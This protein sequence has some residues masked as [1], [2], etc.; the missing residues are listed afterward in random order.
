MDNVNVQKEV[1]NEENIE[2]K[3]YFIFTI[4]VW[5]IAWTIS[6]FLILF[7]FKLIGF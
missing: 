5:V 6:P 2:E 4:F 3:I 7:L 1:K